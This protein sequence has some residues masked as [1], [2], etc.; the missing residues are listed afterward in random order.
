[1]LHLTYAAEV[2]Y[3][4]DLALL[5]R[6]LLLRARIAERIPAPTPASRHRFMLRRPAAVRTAPALSAATAPTGAR[7]TWPRPI[8]EHGRLAA[9]PSIAAP[10]MAC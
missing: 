8:A 9:T 10:A 4:H 6:E 1:M 5:E 2:Q 7:L 3:Q